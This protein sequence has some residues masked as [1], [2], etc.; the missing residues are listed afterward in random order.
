MPPSGLA[1]SAR[2]CAGRTLEHAAPAPR[3]PRSEEHVEVAGLLARAAGGAPGARSLRPRRQYDR[4]HAPRR[5]SAG[6]PRGAHG[7]LPCGVQAVTR[8]LGRFAPALSAYVRPLREPRPSRDRARLAHRPLERQA[9]RDPLQC[10]AGYGGAHFARA[11]RRARGVSPDRG[12]L[13]V[14]PALVEGREAAKVHLQRALRGRRSE[15][16]VAPAVPLRALSRACTR[17]V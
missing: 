1:A 17:L 8:P 6:D 2:A 13:G 12:S 4:A 16:H 11:A 9:L 5:R 3:H 10:L 14:D 15:T 7:N